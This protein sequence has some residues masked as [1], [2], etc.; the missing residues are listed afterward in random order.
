[1][2]TTHHAY[3][4]GRCTIN[5]LEN[6]LVCDDSEHVL[7][8][9][10]IELLGCLVAR[11]PEPITREELINLV[12]DGNHFVG[13]KALTNAIWHLRKAF[14]ELDPN[15]SYIETLRKTGY[16]LVQSP[17]KIE[18][19]PKKNIPSFKRAQVYSVA[20]VFILCVF[21]ACVFWYVSSYQTKQHTA[22]VM[23]INS[24]ES[25]TA[26]P[27]REIYPAVSNDQ[28]YLVY[29]WRRLDKSADL[30]LRDLHF[31]EHPAKQLTDSVE[32]EGRSVFS[33]DSST[34]YY[35]RYT[36]NSACEIVKL[37]LVNAT[38]VVLSECR[39]EGGT[40][41]DVS[42]DGKTLAYIG[43]YVTEAGETVS[44]IKLLSL[45]SDNLHETSIPCV[46]YCHINDESVSFSPDA[47]HVV[48]TRN[49]E[50]DQ[51]ALFMIDVQTGQAKRLT[52]NFAFIHGVD[53]HPSKNLL[54]FSATKG[55]K[56]YGFFYDIE[57]QKLINTQVAGMS[58]PRYSADG[59]V[60]FHQWD[61]D[62]VI[63][64]LKIDEQVASSPFSM[65]STN[66]SSLFPE[67]N[68]AQKKLLY[69]S[70]ESGSSQLWIVNPDASSRK[71]LTSFP[72]VIGQILDPTWSKDGR[73]I[74]F[75]VLDKGLSTLYLYDFKL[76]KR[77]ALNIP[78]AYARKPT[79]SSDNQ[80][81]LV[82]D[83]DYVYRFDLKGNNLGKVISS[84]AKYA[85]E[86]SSGDILFTDNNKAIWIKHHGTG[87]EQVLVDDIH[88]ARHF[89]WLFV[90]KNEYND[91]RIYYFKVRVGDY[92][93]SY[94][95]LAKKQHFD[96]MALPERA[97][98]RSSGLTY[99]DDE[100]WLVYTG[101]LSPEIEIKRLPAAFLPQ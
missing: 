94:Y 6:K 49:V 73:Y 11:Y 3:R 59:S 8:P 33:P 45:A 101:Y 32:T 75:S 39:R 66:F 58:S 57:Q 89:S 7:Q 41:L 72:H 80:S 81:I 14:K 24:I 78:F 12:W 10:F 9:K 42:A 5:P 50:N 77:Q 63:T 13:E 88:L 36:Q 87:Q 95:D 74:L 83:N 84:P 46:D 15:S 17:E 25:V 92:R 76:D 98:S 2:E 48:V 82:S 54:V 99:V 26:S 51:Q 34:L 38:S 69:V 30:Y 79:W 47:K 56:R 21:A 16:R 53:W 60:Y 93:I 52:P 37:S 85:V 71:Q 40:D 20:A 68:S 29:S 100:R 43:E 96:V 91:A 22:F 70:N 61:I 35:Y 31:P 44:R 4:L 86:L 67:Y 97:Y 18:Q 1:M 19:Q 27:G 23:P 55:G 65:L 28:H 62:K 64:R 90:E